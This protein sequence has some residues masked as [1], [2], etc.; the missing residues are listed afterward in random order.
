MNGI[1]NPLVR[2]AKLVPWFDKDLTDVDT[3]HEEPS[4]TYFMVNIRKIIL[5]I[6]RC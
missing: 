5:K 2:K 1:K 4:D 6:P 3:K